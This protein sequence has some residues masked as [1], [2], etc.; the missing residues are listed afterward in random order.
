MESNFETLTNLERT[1]Q[2]DAE[3]PLPTLHE[4]IIELKRQ[5]DLLDR[6]LRDR[7]DIV[8][9]RRQ[10]LFSLSLSLSLSLSPYASNS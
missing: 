6:R 5:V 3:R 4:M 9:V 2:R 8:D 1:I 7:S 10:I